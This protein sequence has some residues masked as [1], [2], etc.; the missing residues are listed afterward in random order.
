MWVPWDTGNAIVKRSRVLIFI[1]ISVGICCF[2]PSILLNFVN[3][4]F[5]L[6]PSLLLGTLV[7]LFFLL[8]SYL[9]L[10]YFFDLVPANCFPMP[11]QLS[12]FPMFITGINA[13]SSV[14]KYLRPNDQIF[15]FNHNLLG[16]QTLSFP[17]LSWMHICIKACDPNK[18]SFIP[19]PSHP[20]SLFPL[21]TA[22]AFLF[23]ECHLPLVVWNHWLYCCQRYLVCSF[24]FTS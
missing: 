1:E 6:T 5:I 21:M 17:L 23:C 10:F 12:S 13:Y 4:S 15:F 7:S 11:F 8:W 2:G 20:P 22:A 16:F 3:S 9:V 19:T 18:P 24:C 14:L